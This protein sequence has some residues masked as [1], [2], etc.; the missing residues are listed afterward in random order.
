MPGGGLYLAGGDEATAFRRS[1]H[2]CDLYLAK[3]DSFGL[4]EFRSRGFAAAI[5]R[6]PTA[7]ESFLL[8][9]AGELW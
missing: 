7:L 6:C 4:G 2:Y 3:G 5:S 8:I 9:I 1:L